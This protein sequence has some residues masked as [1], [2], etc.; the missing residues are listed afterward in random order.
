MKFLIDLKNIPVMLSA[1]LPTEL[2]GTSRAQESFN[3]IVTLIRAI[4]SSGGTL[5]FGGHPSI[6]PLVHRVALSSDIGEA[7][8]ILFQDARFRETAPKEVKDKT[9]FKEVRWIKSKSSYRNDPNQILSTMRQEMVENSTAGVFIGGKTKGFIGSIPGLKDEYNRFIKCHPRG[10]AYLLGLLEGEALSIIKEM[11]K[12]G[13]GE[14]NTLTEGELRTLHKTDNIDL[15]C[16][17]IL[18]DLSRWV[19]HSSP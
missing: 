15:A 13:T 3:V 9:I 7:R 11:E 16:S 5:V 14:P 17:L 1:S 10:P 18:A 2:I 4:L 6:T 19:Q 8:I 12:K